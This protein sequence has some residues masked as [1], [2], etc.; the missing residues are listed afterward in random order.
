MQSAIKCLKDNA[1]TIAHP[2]FYTQKVEYMLAM[3]PTYANVL[4]LCKYIIENPETQEDINNILIEWYGT[5]YPTSE[6]LIVLVRIQTNEYG[7]DE[8]F[9][10][11][12]EDIEK[13]MTVYIRNREYLDKNLK[14]T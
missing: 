6:Q 2:Y 4:A 9:H 3:M 1:N 5:N 7:H 8:H 14:I 13:G 11:V 10:Y 12:L